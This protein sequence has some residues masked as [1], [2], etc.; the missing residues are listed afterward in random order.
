MKRIL[1]P[2]FLIP[3]FLLSCGGTE[4]SD[5]GSSP[6]ADTINK[7]VQLPDTLTTSEKDIV[8]DESVEE[9]DT[10]LQAY[11]N[12]PYGNTPTNIRETPGGEVIYE[13]PAGNDYILYIVAKSGKWFKVTEVDAIDEI[14]K[15]PGNSG[16]LHGSVIGF[17]TRNY[18]NE[19]ISLYSKPDKNSEVVTVIKQESFVSLLDV[20]GDWVKV[21]WKNENGF[22]FQGWIEQSWLCGNPLT[23]CC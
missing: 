7:K 21:A 20:D 22:E 17:G 19:P 2:V 14:I 9:F 4:S 11:I 12:D 8:T 13:L 6:E 16:W 1:Y 10:P 18:G 3:L 5:N 15:L 23:N